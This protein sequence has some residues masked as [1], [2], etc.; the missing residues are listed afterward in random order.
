MPF[1]GDSGKKNA[2]RR[3]T[4]APATREKRPGAIFF[5]WFFSTR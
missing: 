4:R 1:I 5:P 2:A 3:R